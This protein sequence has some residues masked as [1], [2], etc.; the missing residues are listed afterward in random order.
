MINPSHPYISQDE[1]N[2]MQR[3][4]ITRYVDENGRN[5]LLHISSISADSIEEEEEN[6]N[7][8]CKLT[9]EKKEEVIRM[10]A[11]LLEQGYSRNKIFSLLEKEITDND[12]RV[13]SLPTFYK[14]CADALKRVTNVSIAISMKESGKSMNDVRAFLEGKVT[15]K[16]ASAIV[17]LAFN[18]KSD[19]P[20]AYMDDALPLIA[21]GLSNKEIAAQLGCS[22]QYIVNLRHRIKKKN[23]SNERMI[24]EDKQ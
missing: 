13:L 17:R 8:N 4:Q 20:K 21:K 9:K 18:V 15:Q 1:Y 16:R 11:D 2:D 10:C 22:N 3:R 12:G 23:A 7:T 24:K 6:T 14:L 5:R 19:I